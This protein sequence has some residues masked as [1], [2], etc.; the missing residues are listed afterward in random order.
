MMG[1]RRIARQ[2]SKEA[3]KVLDGSGASLDTG[4]GRSRTMSEAISSDALPSPFPQDFPH[5]SNAS[6]PAPRGPV[7]NAKGLAAYIGTDVSTVWRGVSEGRL[8]KPF[9]PSSRAARWRLSEVD[10]ALDATRSSAA[11]A[12]AARQAK[13]LVR[14]EGLAK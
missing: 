14:G 12:R 6:G 7:V 3:Q 10:A 8:P 11:E 13:R 1:V 5:T 4:L 2:K 9:Y